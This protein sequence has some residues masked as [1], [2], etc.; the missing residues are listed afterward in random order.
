MDL[1]TTDTIYGDDDDD[2]IH[3]ASTA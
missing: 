3:T 1:S 2:D